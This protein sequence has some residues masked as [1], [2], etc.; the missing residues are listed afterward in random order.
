MPFDW[1]KRRLT[2]PDVSRPPTDIGGDDGTATARIAAPRP[3]GPSRP[4]SLATATRDYARAVEGGTLDRLGVDAHR[5]LLLAMGPEIWAWQR[6]RK[7]TSQT[8]WRAS[9]NRGERHERL[10]AMRQMMDDLTTWEQA[11]ATLD[12][13]AGR[14]RFYN[15]PVPPDL[16]VPPA[17]M[18]L[19]EA[20]RAAAEERAARRK[21]RS[22]E[23]GGG[24]ALTPDAAVRHP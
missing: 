13:E 2:T 9:P 22:D 5:R 10:S 15:G 4:V 3:T 7:L 8:P 14:A 18:R 23:G 17:V 21:P 20:R 19:I 24:P 6:A 1:L 12:A 11:L 16:E